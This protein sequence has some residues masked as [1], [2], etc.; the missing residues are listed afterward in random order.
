MEYAMRRGV[1]LSTLRRHIKAGKV[2]YRVESGRYL[3]WDEAATPEP[4]VASKVA[5]ESPRQPGAPEAAADVF[6]LQ[7]LEKELKMAR[8]EIAELKMLVALYEEKLSRDP[9]ET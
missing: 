3:L 8:E 6:K 5:V 1:S 7:K 4:W 2:R 9:F